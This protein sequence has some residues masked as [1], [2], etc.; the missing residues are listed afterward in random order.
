MTSKIVRRPDFAGGGITEDERRRMAEHV[1]LWTRRAFRTKPIDAGRIIPAIEGIYA[2]AGLAR[3]RIVIVP[4]P[5]VMA[6][7]GGFSAAIWYLRKICRAAT[8]TAT[9]TATRAATIAATR[10]ATIEIGRA[11]V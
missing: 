1:E 10:A 11:H 3:P 5:L 4:S 9:D 8:D 6:V 7:A 2:A